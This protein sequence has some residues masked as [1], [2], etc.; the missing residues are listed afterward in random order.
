VCAE[1]RRSVTTPRETWGP[2]ETRQLLKD[3][4]EG[5]VVVQRRQQRENN[6]T[7]SGAK[8]KERKPPANTP[9]RQIKKQPLLEE[10]SRLESLRVMTEFVTS[11]DLP[12]A[13]VELTADEAELVE[14]LVAAA[15]ETGSTVRICGGWVRDKALGRLTKDIDVALDNCSGAAF[16]EKVASV[17]RTKRGTSASRVGVIAANPDQSKHLETATMRLCGVEVDFVNLRSEAYADDSSRVPTHVD[18]GT[19]T[20]DALRR[21][22]TVNALMFNVHSRKIEDWTGQG[23]NDLRAGLLRTPLCP[24]VTLLDDP[25]RA[26]RGVRFAARYG[27]ALDE[28]F[29]GACRDPHVRAALLTKVSRERVGK[30]IK[31]AFGATAKGCVRAVDELRRLNLASAALRAVNAVGYEG[32]ARAI[33]ASGLS[34]SQVP[35]ASVFPAGDDDDDDDDASEGG[36]SPAWRY[37]ARCVAAHAAAAFPGAL[38]D[39]TAA[40]KARRGGAA[41]E[42]SIVALAAALLPFSFCTALASSKKKHSPVPVAVFRDGLKLPNSDVQ[43]VQ[44][45]LDAV[46]HVRAL[47]RRVVS[48][49]SSVNDTQLRRDVG[50]FLFD[51]KDLWRDTADLARAADVAGLA[52]HG[53]VLAVD[54]ARP[55]VKAVLDEYAAFQRAV[56]D[57]GL[58]DVWTT[59]VP[60]Y[61]GN[62]L[63][64]ELHVPPGRALG[65]LLEAQRDFQLANPAADRAACKAHLALRLEALGPLPASHKPRSSKKART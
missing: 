19:P 2:R 1:R 50:T 33:D 56:D 22:F 46:P 64:A 20:Q 8:R 16:A 11:E 63:M 38:A 6:S 34:S 45:L 14:I 37:A 48:S 42:R 61:D 31:G 17:L 47:A 35:C 59:L 62:S 52:I 36:S 28:G 3:A 5:P 13:E 30:E 57:F 32:D 18:F 54:L 43:T 25:L 7:S 58:A 15:E 23:W 21:D 9:R 26:L 4:A 49:T 53:N 55:D 29:R 65:V 51:L 40:F 39:D 10:S 60:F 27:F 12:T 44:R 41:A 24:K